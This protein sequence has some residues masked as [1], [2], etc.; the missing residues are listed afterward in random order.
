MY[1]LVD[2]NNFY[3][4]CE[5]VFAPHLEKRPV[6]VL[7]N[8][9]GCVVA[10]SEEVKALGVEMG[11]PVFQ[12]E[13]LIKE[14]RIAVFS[15]NY[16]LY[17]DM[18]DRIMKL[19][20]AF[21]PCQ[22]IYSIDETFLDLSAQPYAD[23]LDLGTRMRETV[24][25][26][27]GIPVCVGIAATKVL[28][29]MANRYAKKKHRDVGV[30]WAANNDLVQ[31]MLDFTEVGDIWGIGAKYA[32][33]LQNAGFRTAADFVK[34]PDD[35]VRKKMSVVG[36]RLLYEL[37][38]IP[39]YEWEPELK[40]KKNIGTSRSFGSLLTEKKDMA[41]AMADYAA[42]CALKLRRQHSY[43]K[44]LQVFVQT[45][46][47]RT[48]LPQ[49]QAGIV[50]DMETASN[51]T[52]QLVKYAVKGLDMIFR[53]GYSYKRCGVMVF[54]LV[55]ET[56]V[57]TNLFADTAGNKTRR[58]ME[59]MDGINDLLGRGKVR[60]AV[61]GHEKKHQLRARHLSPK[62]TTQL[63]EVCKINIDAA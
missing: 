37:R 32:A 42:N 45:H 17:G 58:L 20:S 50:L 13:Q 21:S 9:D 39:N 30:Y 63:G 11:A 44:S 56:V 55:P 59:A 10:R 25:R 46:P 49:Y 7:S 28:A 43:C 62:Y 34:A 18:S 5:R 23:L 51:A 6:L 1:A 52:T 36:L 8:N 16:T 27:T 33:L 47:F 57:Q 29:K 24:G 22:E 38:G 12:L 4:S 15:S 14:H 48:D 35:W 3:C 19:L 41:A 40:P 54:D 53:P 31:Q 26:C 2:C 60:M 61:Q